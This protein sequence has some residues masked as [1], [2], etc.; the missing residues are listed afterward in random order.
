M[1]AQVPY[2]ARLAGQ[3]VEPPALRP[4]RQLLVSDTY[5]PA[6]RSGR[7]G[8]PSLGTQ[9]GEPA[10][11]A[12]LD[13]SGDDSPRP[14][15]NQAAR[16]PELVA[17]PRGGNPGTVRTDGDLG[18]LGVPVPQAIAPGA[19]APPAAAPTRATAPGAPVPSPAAGT[20]VPPTAPAAQVGPS[21][22]SAAPARRAAGSDGLAHQAAASAAR[23][24]PD[25]MAAAPVTRGDARL[26][27]HETAPLP[28]REPPRADGGAQARD[29]TSGLRGGPVDLPQAAGPS[30][31]PAAPAPGP[32]PGRTG[33]WAPGQHTGTSVAPGASH[34]SDPDRLPGP[35]PGQLVPS[36][37]AAPGHLLPPSAPAPS[38][39]PALGPAPGRSHQG[40]PARPRVSIGTIEVTVVQPAPRAS[41]APKTLPQAQAAQGLPRPARQT[42]EGAG[43]GR[44]RD[45]LRRWYGIAQG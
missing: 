12:A 4:P 9:A 36:A 1:R 5:S 11:P 8:P 18:L 16:A 22:P 13:M 6:R 34:R 37:S 20:V 38:P 43:T 15:S 2:L 21:D 7:S 10:W 3:T 44:L 17:S 45:G 28:P 23:A 31:R 33:G 30:S 24:E 26:T 27:E 19:P 32:V 25:T 14:G 39:G 29:W 35:A 40:V 41:E 42:A